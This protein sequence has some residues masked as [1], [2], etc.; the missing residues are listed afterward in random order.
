MS[1][2]TY[3]SSRVL[4]LFSLGL[5]AYILIKVLN[6]SF[7]A[8]EDT[9]TPFYIAL[10]CVVLNIILSLL[11]IGSFREMGIALATAFRLGS[12]F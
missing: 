3:Y 10:G 12:M 7:F 6:P 2:D 5:P 9:K 4:S 11:L 1:V 8:R